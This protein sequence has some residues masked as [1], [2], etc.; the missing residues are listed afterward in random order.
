MTTGTDLQAIDVSDFKKRVQDHVVNTFGSLIPPQQF[1]ALVNAEIKAFFEQTVSFE[2]SRV[3]SEWGRNIDSFKT[4]MTPFRAVVWAKTQQMAQEAMRDFFNGPHAPVRKILDELTQ[5]P[6]IQGQQLS[7]AQQL[8]L[9]MAGVMFKNVMLSANES[10][11]MT[12]IQRLRD[13]GQHDVANAL[14]AGFTVYHEETPEVR[15]GG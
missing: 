1:E 11:L 8:M 14:S 13:Q 6:E 2:V 5:L 3:H 12:L 9:A 10:S 4:A 15:H 7:Q